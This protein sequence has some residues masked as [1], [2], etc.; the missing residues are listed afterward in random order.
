[1]KFTWDPRKDA[2]NILTHGVDFE[3]AEIAFADPKRIFASDKK[4]SHAETRFFCFG[5]VQG[6]VLT[7]RFILR[8][9]DIRIIGAGYWR[10]GRKIYEKENRKESDI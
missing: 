5:L 2:Q 7:V 10:E 8:G 1:V 3:T 6:R 4:H 9:G